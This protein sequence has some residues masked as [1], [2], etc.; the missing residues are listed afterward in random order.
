MN[1]GTVLTVR[2]FCLHFVTTWSISMVF[3]CGKYKFPIYWSRI[4]AFIPKFYF[5]WTKTG[6]LQKENKWCTIYTSLRHG[7][8]LLS[9]HNILHERKLRC[10]WHKSAFRENI[11]L[12]SG[13]ILVLQSH[14][15]GHV[16]HK[17]PKKDHSLTINASLP[18]FLR[19][20]ATSKTQCDHHM[21][22]CVCVCV[23]THKGC[24][25]RNSN[26]IGRW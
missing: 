15:E 11:R 7:G 8:K 1:F 4:N 23:Y 26:Y 16:T 22:V 14:N 21:C 3:E 12:P 20:L 5:L 10:K 25:R 17:M 24:F 18:W 19:V 2:Q 9:W 6:Q 13:A